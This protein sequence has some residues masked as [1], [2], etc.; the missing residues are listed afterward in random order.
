MKSRRRVSPL[1]L[2][3]GL[4]VLFLFG[5]RKRASGDT[6]DHNQFREDVLSCEDAVSHLAECCPDFDPHAIACQYSYEE[7]DEPSA[8]PY[9]SGGY[10]EDDCN[11]GAGGCSSGVSTVMQTNPDLDVGTSECIRAASCENLVMTGVC[12]RVLH[13]DPS[14]RSA[15]G[16]CL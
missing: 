9:N 3:A 6:S 2:C 7:Q 1:A 10:Y 13:I 8:C 15:V 11:P 4:T 16:A 5:V 12:T 14:A